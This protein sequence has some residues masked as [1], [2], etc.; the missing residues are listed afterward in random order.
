[1]SWFPYED[2]ASTT[3]INFPVVQENHN[4]PGGVLSLFFRAKLSYTLT[5]I[6]TNSIKAAE[7][8]K[9]ITSAS[10]LTTQHR[11]VS[12]LHL[13]KPWYLSASL[14]PLQYLSPGWVFPYIIKLNPI[15][16]L[17][18]GW[19]FPGSFQLLLFHPLHPI[20]S[21]GR[22]QVPAIHHKIQLRIIN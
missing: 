3:P 17:S 5:F 20:L 12:L 18:T 1:M 10:Y 19:I 13:S 8:R 11:P 7:L 9:S 2:S 6:P 14:P 4:W 22:R 21:T 15:Q 16:Y